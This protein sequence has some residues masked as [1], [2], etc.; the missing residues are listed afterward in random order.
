MESRGVGHGCP[1][2]RRG[3]RTAGSQERLRG[4]GASPSVPWVK[5]HHQ[6]VGEED[7]DP[8]AR[9]E[10]PALT[11]AFLQFPRANET[12]GDF[13]KTPIRFTRVPT[14]AGPGTAP[15]KRVWGCV[16]GVRGGGGG[17]GEGRRQLEAKPSFLISVFPIASHAPLAGRACCGWPRRAHSRTEEGGRSA[18]STRKAEAP[19]AAAQ[20]ACGP[21][22]RCAP[23]RGSAS[24]AAWPPRGPGGEGP[25][26]WAP[27]WP[28][29]LRPAQTGAQLRGP[30]AQ[31]SF[32]VKLGKCVPQAGDFP[33]RGHSAQRTDINC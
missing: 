22:L 21:P 13:L 18:W 28:G 1:S 14:E 10:N 27:R 5:G 25:R 15:G 19:A 17:G 23:G 8:D 30:R 16:V 31:G 20:A 29:L 33:L 6:R 12:S 11:P 9:A 26:R 24:C 32:T 3:A 4:P 2:G 7:S